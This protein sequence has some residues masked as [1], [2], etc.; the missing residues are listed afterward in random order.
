MNNIILNSDKLKGQ[1]KIVKLTRLIKML[2]WERLSEE[3]LEL[4]SE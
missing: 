4:G 3:I 1:I 2:L